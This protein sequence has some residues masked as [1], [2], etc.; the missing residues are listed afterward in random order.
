VVT[1]RRRDTALLEGRRVIEVDIF[2]AE[3]A[4]AYLRDKLAAQPQPLDQVDELAADLGFLPLA[5]AQAAAYILD[6]GASMTCARYR[7]RL[8]DQ[9]RGLADLAPHALPDQY[10]A[11]VGA[12]WSLS[13][14]R[15]DQLAPVGVARPVLELAALLDPNAFRTTVFAT[16]AVSVYCTTRLGRPVAVE[17][18]DDAVN[19][20]HRFNLLTVD[21]A[22]ATVRIHGL[23]QRAVREATHLDHRSALATIAADALLEMWPDVERDAGHAQMLRA[24]TTALYSGTG[25]RLLLSEIHPVL[26]R[27]A[28]SLQET[29]QI[30]DATAAF[31]QLLDDAL[32]VLGAD[33]RDTLCSRT[34]LVNLQGEAGDV[35]GAAFA[36]KDLLD[37]YLRVFGPDHPE[38]LNTRQGV[39]H[40]RAEAEFGFDRVSSLEQLLND[41]MRVLGPDHPETLT[42]RGNLANARGNCGDSAG[43]A[44]ALEQLIDDYVR[45]LGCHHPSTLLTRNNLAY[46]LDCGGDPSSADV[47]REQ[48]LD[49]YLRVLGPDRP[50]TLTIRGDTADRLGKAGDPSEAVAVFERL[51]NDCNRVLGP[52]HPESL[53]ARRFLADWRGKAGDP[54]GAAAAMEQVVNDHV[55]VLG[56]EHV[57]TWVAYGLLAHWRTEAGDPAGAAAATEES[58]GY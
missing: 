37:D 55:R 10:Q 26:F 25:D 24:N 2:T 1:T 23:V 44:T 56:R 32:R 18:V 8:A 51:L 52:D 16:A 47:A 9:R 42:T 41:C 31:R 36:I 14:E 38:T 50:E 15:A 6:R 13:I 5:L 22:T 45:V 12:T 28:R 27:A 40:W 53:G 58:I 20:L 7:R 54:A 35:T 29:G 46:W 19:L 34:H 49:D 17:D 43:A 30:D 11:A 4:A 48:L 3:Q 39:A 57:D 33:H 21:E